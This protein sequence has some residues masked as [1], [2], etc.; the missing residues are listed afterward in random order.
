MNLGKK[1][2]RLERYII[3]LDQALMKAKIRALKMGLVKACH[4]GAFVE[5]EVD[6]YEGAGVRGME[7]VA[8]AYLEAA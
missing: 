5:G 7:A 4:E 6:A 1:N 2:K 8:A 3:P